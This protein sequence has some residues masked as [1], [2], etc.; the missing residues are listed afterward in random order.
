[1]VGNSWLLGEDYLLAGGYTEAI[2]MYWGMRTATSMLG[3]KKNNSSYSS[4]FTK[5]IF[6]LVLWVPEVF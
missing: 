5:H 2:H 4:Y 1:M 3:G 6:T